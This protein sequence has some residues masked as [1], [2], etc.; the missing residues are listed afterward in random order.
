VDVVLSL[1]DY[2]TLFEAVL[3]NILR[4][5]ACRCDLD[6]SF[7]V[8]SVPPESLSLLCSFSVSPRKRGEREESS[9]IYKVLKEPSQSLITYLRDKAH[10]EF[11]NCPNCNHRHLP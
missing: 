9:K 10:K 6:N 3:T 5:S 11:A 2:R 8:V 7:A 1:F 4:I